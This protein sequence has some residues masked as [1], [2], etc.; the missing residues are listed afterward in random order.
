VTDLRASELF[1]SKLQG[2]FVTVGK[3]KG[4]KERIIPIPFQNIQDYQIATTDPYSVSFIT[5]SFSKAY[6]QVNVHRKTLHALR[7]TFALKSACRIKSKWKS[8]NYQSNI[9]EIATTYVY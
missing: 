5:H 3:S 2:N 9:I 6:K 4:R 7:H 8:E 1:Y